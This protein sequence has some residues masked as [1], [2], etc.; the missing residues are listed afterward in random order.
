MAATSNILGIVQRSGEIAKKIAKKQLEKN[1][2]GA[3]EMNTFGTLQESIDVKLN[4]EGMF[5]ELELESADYGL[6]LDKGF[7]NIPFTKP[8]S[9][10][11]TTKKPSQYILGLTKWVAKK[12][13]LGNNWKLATK[14][15]FAIA[16]KQKD[17]GKAPANPGWIE[18][19]KDD[20]NNQL[21][22]QMT[23]DTMAAIN[24]D[25]MRILNITIP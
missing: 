18:E 15:A 2:G 13:G 23:L 24:T 21:N 19:I 3:L 1:R 16:H 14:I 9:K 25:V 8:K 10:K 7:K 4:I 17:D 6:L 11:A 22:T 20:L 12:Y 5:L